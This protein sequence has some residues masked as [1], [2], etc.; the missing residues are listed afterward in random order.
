[1]HRLVDAQ[2]A[3]LPF[4]PR[5]A[6]R[7]HPPQRVERRLRQ[8]CVAAAGRGAPLRSSGARRAA[9][10][11][12]CTTRQWESRAKQAP[13]SPTRYSR[14][15]VESRVPSCSHVSRTRSARR[16]A[17]PRALPGRGGGGVAAPHPCPALRA[18]ARGIRLARSCTGRNP[19]TTML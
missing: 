19:E 18:T 3:A 11:Q 14:A 15:L 8:G 7:R 17:L 12:P 13:V 16:L 2:H 9:L 5:T 6:A 1:N 10:K 4:C